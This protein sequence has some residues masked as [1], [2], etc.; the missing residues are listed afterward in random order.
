MDGLS[1]ARWVGADYSPSDMAARTQSDD[2]ARGTPPSWLNALLNPAA[3]IQWNGNTPRFRKWNEAFARHFAALVE[4]GRGPE[5][6]WQSHVHAQVAA[7]I[8]SQRDSSR[9]EIERMTPLGTEAFACTLTWVRSDEDDGQYVL[10]NAI[11]RTSDRRIEE[12]LRRELVSDALTAL[13]NR[14]GFGEAVE[15]LLERQGVEPGTPVGILIVD[16]IRFGRINQAL[17]SMAGDELILSIA[18]RLK[19]SADPDVTLARIGGNEFALCL[20]AQ[21]GID[22]VTDLANRLRAAIRA[23]IRLSNLEISTNCAIG[24]SVALA[25][26]TD[27][28]ELIRQAHTAARTAKATDRI[29][30][31]RTGE[32][33]AARQRFLLESRLRTALDRGD[34]QLHYQPIVALNSFSV[35]GFEALARWTDPELGAISPEDFIPV[36]EES[37]LVVQLGRW[38]IGEAMEQLLRWDRAFGRSVP[39]KMNVNLSPIQ[40]MRDDVITTIRDVLAR[41][42]VDGGRLTMELTESAIVGDPENSRSLLQSLKESNVAIAMD[43]FGTGYSNMASLQSLPIDLLKIDRSFVT[44]MLVDPDKLAIVRAILSLAKTLGMKTT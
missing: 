44:D 15:C 6:S 4:P 10:L 14:T 30:I 5:Q 1:S 41:S 9:F 35:V 31:Y 34:L 25:G 26:D 37:G 28:D 13:P 12:S 19:A 20:V 27:A 42:N 24:C 8:L 38:A 23:P 36:A 29:E 17:G 32:L 22:D 21:T 18:S 39:L 16:L 7:F 40:I 11:D 33:G 43:D 3:I 2:R